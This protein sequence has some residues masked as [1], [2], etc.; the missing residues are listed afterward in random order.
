MNILVTGGAGYIGSHAVRRLV[1]D[2]H[3]VTVIDNLGRGHRAAVAAA[4]AAN[5]DAVTFVEL[6]LRDTAAVT[7]VLIDRGIEAVM[8]FAA[9][10]Y[11]G[12]SVTQPLRYYDNNSGGSLS[13]LNAMDAAGVNRL[14]FSSTCATYGEP[15]A[16]QVPIRETCPQWPINPYG[17]SK[18]VTERAMID[19]AAARE[20]FAFAALRYFNVAGSAG[21]G[22]I[23]ED[24]EPETH[25][26]PVALQVALGQREHFTI[27]G[28]DYD[29]PDGTC[30][31]DYIHV[32]D[33]I[34]AHVTAL[35]ALDPSTPD[36]KQ[37]FFNLGT[38]SGMS[39]KQI[40]DAVRGVTGHKVPVVLGPRRP[41][42]P[43]MLYAEPSKIREQLGWSARRTEVRQMVEDAWKWFKAHPEGYSD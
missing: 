42:D 41:G 4:A 9:L 31:R 38:G 34:D 8:H 28:D 19:H 11:V 37:M 35:G 43:P 5:P 22:S 32:E 30:I 29:T 36:R 23:G 7:K 15:P 24:H 26:I 13:L 40:V 2:G 27:F 1:D 12:E 25:I 18:L 16:D 6:D 3:T 10:A 33:L 17:W 14:V 39:V 21:D 20:G